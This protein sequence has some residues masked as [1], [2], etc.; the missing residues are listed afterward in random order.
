MKEPTKPEIAG[1]VPTGRPTEGEKRAPLRTVTFLADPEVIEAIKLL[2]G[3]VR[4]ERGRQS[5]AIRRAILG[6][7]ALRR[8]A[9]PIN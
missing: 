3:D 8:G 7:A 9:Q 2:A 6:Q 1:Q 4:E 5:I